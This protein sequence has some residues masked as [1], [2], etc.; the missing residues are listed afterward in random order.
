MHGM[1]I[2]INAVVFGLSAFLLFLAAHVCLWRLIGAQ[3]KGV[4]LLVLTACLAYIGVAISARVWLASGAIEHHA[5]LAWFGLLVM[6]YLHFYVGM[7]RSVSV[8]MLGELM[9]ADGEKMAVAELRQRYSGRDM[10][11]QR[12]ALMVRQKWLIEENGRF[13][14]APKAARLARLTIKLR[15]FYRIAASG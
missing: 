15:N 3:H 7:D 10:V 13:V 2:L 9:S 5:A 1:N 12:V 8:R 14:C 11:A 6:F 4:K